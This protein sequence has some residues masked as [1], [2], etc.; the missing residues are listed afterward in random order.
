VLL[1]STIIG[2]FLAAGL[3]VALSETAAEPMHTKKAT[4]ILFTS[5]T[6]ETLAVEEARSTQFSTTSTWLVGSDSEQ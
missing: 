5:A 1:T 6:V 2:G 4:T 3:A